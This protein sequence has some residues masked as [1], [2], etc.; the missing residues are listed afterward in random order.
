MAKVNQFTVK[1]VNIHQLK[2]DVVNFDGTKN[3]GWYVK[4]RGDGCAKHTEFKRHAA[5]ARDP[6]ETLE[7]D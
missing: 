6:A 1:T 4:M 3:F 2:I 7:K 5:F